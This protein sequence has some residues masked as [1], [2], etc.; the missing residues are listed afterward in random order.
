MHVAESGRRYR[1]V[2]EMPFVLSFNLRSGVNF[3]LFLCFFGSR[4]KKIT[5][6]TFI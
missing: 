4:G 2:V 1:P 5:P 6:N 3:F